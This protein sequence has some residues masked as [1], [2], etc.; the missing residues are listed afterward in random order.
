MLNYTASHENVSGNFSF[1]LNCACMYLPLIYSYTSKHQLSN[2][3]SSHFFFLPL[4]RHVKKEG[5]LFFKRNWGIYKY[6]L[7]ERRQGKGG[8]C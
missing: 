5:I 8:A 4:Q 7:G 1:Y 3:S 2:S 6:S